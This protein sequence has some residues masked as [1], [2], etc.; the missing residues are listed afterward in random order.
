M[1]AKLSKKKK[2]YCLG[3][4]KDGE[5]TDTTEVE[6]KE[7]GNQDGPK[8]AAESNGEKPS[9]N[10]AKSCDG[11]VAESGKQPGEGD[12]T[13]EDTKVDQTPDTNPTEKQEKVEMTASSQ[14]DTENVDTCSSTAQ[15]QVSDGSKGN[16]SKVEKSECVQEANKVKGEKTEVALEKAPV[17]ETLA[18]EVHTKPVQE[19]KPTEQQEKPPV[20]V[21]KELEVKQ[22]PE[23][24]K[25]EADGLQNTPEPK[26]DHPKQEAVQ[27]AQPVAEVSDKAHES[28]PEAKAPEQAPKADV[29]NIEHEN[30]KKPK[31]NETEI[32]VTV[33]SVQIEAESKAEPQQ[34]VEPPVDALPPTSINVKEQHAH[35]DNAS[36]QKP[37]CDGQRADQQNTQVEKRETEMRPP[38]VVIDKPPEEE[39]NSISQNGPTEPCKPENLHGGPSDPTEQETQDLKMEEQDNKIEQS[40]PKPQQ[41]DLV[42]ERTKTEVAEELSSQGHDQT[43]SN[44]ESTNNLASEVPTIEAPTKTVNTVSEDEHQN[45]EMPSEEIRNEKVSSEPQQSNDKHLISNGLPVKENLENESDNAISDLNG[46]NREIVCI[47]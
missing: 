44:P 6:Q 22:T 36:D 46:Q 13:K 17:P 37:E 24:T 11:Q 32:V 1:G 45:H 33:E 10:Q 15:E 41:H 19:S 42:E 31:D 14:G 39:Q 43:A 16:D 9:T 18:S 38:K 12:S 35:G 27:D 20:V 30:V 29:V 3:A 26:A 2:G 4:G 34:E 21:E 7:T 40:T 23:V 28:T 5:S 47:E 8:D 25:K